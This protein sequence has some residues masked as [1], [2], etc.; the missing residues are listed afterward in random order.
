MS[1]PSDSPQGVFA[2]FTKGASRLISLPEGF[3][4]A[5][6]PLIDDL[7]ELKLTLYC[8]WMLHQREGEFRYLRARDFRDDK[9]LAAALGGETS[10]LAA[11]NRVVARGTLI[12]VQIPINGSPESVYLM[13]TDKGR[14]SAESLLKGEWLPGSPEAP[15][16]LTGEAPN[17]FRLYEQNIGAL[18]PLL[19]ETLR[20]AEKTY[21][22]DW[23]A[24]GFQIA[25]ETNRRNWRYIEAILKRW[26][27]E[28]KTSPRRPD[29]SENVNPYLKDP[30]GDDSDR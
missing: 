5:L 20:D 3:F 18:T 10:L 13:N 24:E 29:T 30:Y 9:A 7:D 19:A 23:I 14:R 8:F 22:H 4:S 15:I 27:T 17:I 6:L 28:G 1:A 2:G 12:E 21:P 11:L 26:M 16:V 25:V